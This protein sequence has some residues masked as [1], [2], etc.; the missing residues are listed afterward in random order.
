MKHRAFR[1]YPQAILIFFLMFSLFFVVSCVGSQ[2]S[3][4]PGFYDRGD[5]NL[6]V[7]GSQFA[8]YILY[9]F[10]TATSN[11]TLITPSAA[12]IVGSYN[13]VVG[14]VLAFAVVADG[15]HTVTIVGGTNVTVK[16]SASTV[17]GNT[18]LM[19][20]FEIEN[21]NSGTEAVTIY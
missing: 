6:T 19:I 7:T 12:D 2:S 4:Q 17:A 8:Q 18:T 21:V 13:P 14:D 11:H 1:C 20:F 16:P 9:R 5:N 10:D 15:T 3:S